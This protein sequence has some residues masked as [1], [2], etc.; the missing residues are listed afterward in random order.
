[1]SCFSLRPQWYHLW[2]VSPSRSPYPQWD[3]KAKSPLYDRDV[4]FLVVLSLMQRDEQYTKTVKPIVTQ[5]VHGVEITSGDELNRVY[6]NPHGSLFEING[7][8]SDGE[9]VV[10]REKD[11]EVIS[12]TVVRGQ[13]LTHK[14]REILNEVNIVN[15]TN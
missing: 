9:K 14:G 10:I 7:V 3:V 15:R 4:K 8:V 12:W 11:G 2:N 6:F 13:K 1:M 5:K